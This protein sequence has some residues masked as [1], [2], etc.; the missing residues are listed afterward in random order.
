[1]KKLIIII[2]SLVFCAIP[3]FAKAPD[4]DTVYNTDAISFS[5]TNTYLYKAPGNDFIILEFHW[6]NITNKPISFNMNLLVTGYQN[7]RELSMIDYEP[8]ANTD[9][10]SVNCMTRI[11]PGYENTDYEFIPIKDD[12][13]VTIVVDKAFEV[14]NSFE[15][16]IYTV[17]P[18]ELPEF[19]WPK[20]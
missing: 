18:G 10:M 17:I 4:S 11:M 13:E 1:M 12:S 14:G 8:N 3:T 16:I 7:D 5:I 20:E 15:D 2:L 19:Q 9:T 6:K